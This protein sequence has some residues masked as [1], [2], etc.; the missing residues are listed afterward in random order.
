MFESDVAEIWDAVYAGRGRDYASEARWVEEQVRVRY[1]AATTLLDVACGTG[2]HL[3]HLMPL[4]ERV[5][6]VELSEDMIEWGRPRSP[7]LPLHQ[8]DM[9]DFDLGRQ[10]SAVICLFS[11]VGHMITGHDLDLAVQRLAAHTER[12]GVVIVEPWW[13]PDE[14]IEGYVVGDVVRSDGRVLAR[15]SHS[16]KVGDATRIQAHFVVADPHSGLRHFTEDFPLTLFPRDR[17]EEAF[18]RAGLSCFYTPDSP[19]GPGAF[20]GTF[21]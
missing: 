11:S 6:G 5:E 15:V 20:I 9:R 17:Y 14:F 13:F 8:G 1:P 16:T 18:E 3:R 21:D 12:G 10:F 7:D 19:A 2:E 4:F